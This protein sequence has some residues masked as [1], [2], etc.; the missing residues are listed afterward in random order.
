MLSKY[1]YGHSLL[2]RFGR[3]VRGRYARRE[4]W[5]TSHDF[6]RVLW[7]LYWYPGNGYRRNVRL[8]ETKLGCCPRK[9]RRTC[10]ECDCSTLTPAHGNR[11]S[12]E[13]SPTSATLSRRALIDRLAHSDPASNRDGIFHYGK[14][15]ST[16]YAYLTECP[17][18]RFK[19]RGT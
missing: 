13:F 19:A 11:Y 17:E 16:S 10:L 15:S 12:V 2:Q 6:V 4:D 8:Y 9:H 5:S 18:Q 1:S 3:R 14:Q 7:C